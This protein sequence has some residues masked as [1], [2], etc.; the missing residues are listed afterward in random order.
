MK[1]TYVSTHTLDLQPGCQDWEMRALSVNKDGILMMGDGRDGQNPDNAF[2]LVMASLV[3]APFKPNEVISFTAPF[4][5]TQGKKLQ[6]P[7][8]S[9]TGLEYDN[10]G[11]LHVVGRK[12][13]NVAGDDI[14]SRFVVDTSGSVK[15]PINIAD[16]NDLK[17]GGWVTKGPGDL[18][19]FGGSTLQGQ[20][21]RS[22]GPS[23]YTYEWN[24]TDMVLKEEL[25]AYPRNCKRIEGDKAEALIYPQA[26]YYTHYPSFTPADQWDSALWIGNKLV[27]FVR[28]GMGRPFYGAPGADDDPY[29]GTRLKTNKGHHA[30]PYLNQMVTF[31]L[32]TYAYHP[33]ERLPEEVKEIP[34]AEDD[35]GAVSGACRFG[36][37]IYL[38]ISK[39]ED[40]S[41]PPMIL[42][43]V[44]G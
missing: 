38:L 37:F 30:D 25:L 15:G 36:N 2:G 5:V 1:L 23:C 29:D 34:K 14:G 31:D 28:K 40:G 12:Y 21:Y 17:L 44:V 7:S 43:Y 39:A 42:Q 33:W 26:T 8:F 11:N 32:N 27:C 13:Y 6:I 3:P 24:G 22:Q 16:V 41:N 19:S 10:A 4:D 18:M 9:L 35:R 20:Q